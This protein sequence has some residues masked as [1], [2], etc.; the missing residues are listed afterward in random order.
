M[1]ARLG[2]QVLFLDAAHKFTD[3][4]GGGADGVILPSR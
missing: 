3:A 1:D 4:R 2:G